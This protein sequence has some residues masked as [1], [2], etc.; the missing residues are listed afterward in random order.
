M[1]TVAV[2]G[3]FDPLHGGHLRLFKQAAKIGEVTVILNSNTWL[4]RKKGYYLMSWT[5]RAELLRA[6][7]CV[8]NVIEVSDSD[9]TVCIALDYLRPDIFCNGGD[10]GKENTPEQQ[11][12]S[13]LNIACMFGI[14]GE[15]KHNSSTEM[16]ERVMNHKRVY[17]PW[18]WWQ[19]I[20]EQPG[21]KVKIL[22]VYARKSLS[23]QYHHHRSEHWQVL[24]GGI[25]A[26]LEY[27][28]HSLGESECINIPRQALHQL[29]N[30]DDKV[31]YVL[32]VQRG[33]ICEESDIVRL[34]E[35]K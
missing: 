32:E 14:G 31:A 16:V 24:Q 35:E 12:C 34:A 17:R 4:V 13:E 15:T 3:G 33:A 6:L 5:E 11:L 9:E 29:I 18:G 25:I 7:D 23:H 27:K 21:Y 2:S 28:E 20:F 19:P 30:A 1:T 8:D 10:R 22:C 26:K